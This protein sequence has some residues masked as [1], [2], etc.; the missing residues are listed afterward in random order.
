MRFLLVVGST[1]TALIDGLSA[2]GS[3][4]AATRHTPV[5]DAEILTFGQ[6]VLAPEVPVSPT[7]C[8]TPAVVTR[9]IKDV[10][11]FDVLTVD[12][13]L[14]ERAAAPTYQLGEAPGAD[15]REP[16]AVPNAANLFDG[17]REFAKA[18]PDDRLVIG[19]SIPGGTTTALGVLRALGEPFEV[20]SSLPENPIDLKRETVRAGL[21]ASG[22]SEG[23]LDGQPGAA[24]R[25]MGDPVLGTV[26]GL[27]AG[28]KERWASVTLAGGT[29]MIAAAALARHSGV[30]GPI[31][32]ATTSYIAADETVDLSTAAD[33]LNLKL[34]VTDP[35]FD[36][37][38]HP[39][40]A[41]Y[42]AGEAKEGVGMGGALWWATTDG[43]RMGEIR[44]AVES[45]YD[46]LVGSHGP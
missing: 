25:L 36:R 38:D 22:I 32:L 26:A 23:E 31:R 37:S 46:Q 41:R 43:I 6:P 44:A 20:S 28:A 7:G 27:I 39:S 4:P 10:L 45:R 24:V 30:N 5:A 1:R 8:P 34:E 2:A 18:L 15:I 40:M 19:E 12:A 33:S 11:D 14:A 29:Q 35:G 17:A 9:A 3:S 13:G 42:P 16:E 21:E